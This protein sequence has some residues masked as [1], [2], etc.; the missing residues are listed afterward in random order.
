MVTK[1]QVVVL[2]KTDKHLQYIYLRMSYMT[3]AGRNKQVVYSKL[4]LSV[5]PHMSIGQGKTT[6]YHKVTSSCYVVT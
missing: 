5:I 3:N 2:I 1:P 6:I 4:Q